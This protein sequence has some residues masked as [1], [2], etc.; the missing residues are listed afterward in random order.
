MQEEVRA[1]VEEA[2]C[3]RTV[4]MRQQGAW[5]RWEEA[6]DRKISWSE[7]WRL[8]PHQIKFLIQTVHN[9]LLSPSN[10]FCW[11]LAETPLCP[12]CQNPGSPEHI[13]RP[14]NTCGRALLLAA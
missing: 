6:A 9:V 1:G 10:L 14:T 4:G 13:L 5:T 7:L 12:L 3:T 8:E 11:G 2:S